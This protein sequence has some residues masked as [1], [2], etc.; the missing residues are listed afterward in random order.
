MVLY[1]TIGQK[2]KGS[3]SVRCRLA[4]CIDHNATST[5]KTKRH[6]VNSLTLTLTL[7]PKPNTNPNPNPNFNPNPNSIRTPIPIP[8]TISLQQGALSSPLLFVI[9][10]LQQGGFVS[11]F[12]SPFVLDR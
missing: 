2:C 10:P 5:N 1:L 11:S 3:Q 7:T 6:F 8:I 4:T 9:F 12:L